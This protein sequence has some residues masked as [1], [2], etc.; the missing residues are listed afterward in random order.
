MEKLTITSYMIKDS[1][2]A[3]VMLI[4]IMTVA[5]AIGLSIVQKSLFDVTTSS[6]VEQSSRAFSAAEAGVEKALSENTP[7]KTAFTPGNNSSI[8]DLS[9]KLKPE[10][11][12]SGRQEVL[13]LPGLRREEIGQVWLANFTTSVSANDPRP[14]IQYT[15][16]SLDIYWGNPDAKKTD[17]NSTDYV[18]LELTLV[19]YG[20]PAFGEL[21]DPA[22]PEYR[23]HK[24]Y[25]DNA[26]AG[27]SNN[28]FTPVPT[29]NT[30]TPGTN[31]VKYNCRSTISSLPTGPTTY[32]I[33]LRIRLLY[34]EKPQPFAVQAV[35]SCG[36]FACWLP[37]QETIIDSVGSA[38]ETQRRVNVS[39]LYGVVPS[40]FDYAIFSAGDITK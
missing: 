12:V 40:Y 4:L 29:C 18:A 1:G 28:G 9:K 23:S 39:L 38:G 16:S 25:L 21:T 30:Y 5:L 2:Q 31:N 3:V 11:S 35:T 27:R 37:P 36:S 13:E 24:W 10:V 32:S 22:T 33:L 6:K 19:Y 20:L 14:P 15:Q 26:A 34:N 7:D 17:G 8:S